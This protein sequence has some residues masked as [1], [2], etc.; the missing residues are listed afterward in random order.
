[1]KGICII[2]TLIAGKVE[3]RCLSTV[4]FVKEVDSLSGVT[5]YPDCAKVFD[6]QLSSASKHL[7]TL[8]NT[9]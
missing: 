2:L 1:V 5:C 3:S 7:G 8:E 4:V 9:V 6:C